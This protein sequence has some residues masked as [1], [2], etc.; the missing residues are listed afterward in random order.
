MSKDRNIKSYGD[1]SAAQQATTRELVI[2]VLTTAA[3]IGALIAAGIFGLHL[4]KSNINMKEALEIRATALEAVGYSEDHLYRIDADENYRDMERRD[5]LVKQNA[6]PEEIQAAL[7]QR[8]AEANAYEDVLPSKDA[9]AFAK[10]LSYDLHNAPPARRDGSYFKIYMADKAGDYADKA[11]VIALYVQKDAKM[12]IGVTDSDG[13]RFS[14]KITPDEAVTYD[15]PAFKSEKKRKD[16]EQ[17]KDHSA[18]IIN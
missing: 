7:K 11:G 10:E 15:D 6:S 9:H 12:W 3:I 14:F 5:E 17:R 18:E 13:H 8:R 1:G 2:G 4:W 16:A